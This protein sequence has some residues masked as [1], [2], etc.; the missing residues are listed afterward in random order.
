MTEVQKNK[1]KIPLTVWR[2]FIK[3]NKASW[4]G[5][6]SLDF[7]SNLQRKSTCLSRS[8]STLVWWSFD[9]G[10]CRG[11]T[12]PLWA[13]DCSLKSSSS[14]SLWSPTFMQ[15]S[16]SP[17]RS[18][19][20]ARPRKELQKDAL[21]LDCRPCNGRH[22]DCSQDMRDLQKRWGGGASERGAWGPVLS[23]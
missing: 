19:Q 21:Q 15:R 17:S 3:A 23:F 13:A 5:R 14:A 22:C 4:S 7:R 16:V 8:H 2:F 6:I 1:P 10:F 20:T 18:Q 11:W 12:K 9:W